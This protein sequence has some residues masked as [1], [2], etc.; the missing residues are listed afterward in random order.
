L[1]AFAR[2]GSDATSFLKSGMRTVSTTTALR[3]DSIIQ[4]Y[5][6]MESCR[7]R[8]AMSGVF[9]S[10]Q[11]DAGLGAIIIDSRGFSPSFVADLGFSPIKPVTVVGS[12]EIIR[13]GGGR[14]EAWWSVGARVWRDSAE[15]DTI[16]SILLGAGAI[17]AIIRSII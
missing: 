3:A 15:P 1:E 9:G 6:R 11:L 5:S 17:A 7:I 12:L 4:W 13:R 16:G 2:E 14:D 8:V 10:T